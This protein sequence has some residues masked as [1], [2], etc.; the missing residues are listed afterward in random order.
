MS[1]RIYRRVSSVPVWLLLIVGIWTLPT[2]GLFVDSFRGRSDQIRGGFWTAATD[3]AQLT[4]DNY[5]IVLNRSGAYSMSDSLISSFAIVIPATIIP[6]FLAAL[7]AYGFAFIDFKARKWLFI[8]TISLI[9]VPIQVTL[10]PVLA[11]Y[12]HGAHLTI[13][14]SDR[15][16]TVF[17]DLDVNMRGTTAVWLTQ[18]GFALPFAIFLLHNAFTKLPQELI[19]SARIDG[20]DHVAIFRRLVLPLTIPAL[21]SLTILQFLWNWNDF[22]IPQIMTSGGDPRSL[23]TTVRLANLVGEPSSAGPVAA[24]GTFVQAAVPLLVFFA[25]QRHIVRGLLAG[26]VNG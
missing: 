6:I 19:D 8:G 10:I 20:A 5:D 21:M 14:F 15:T 25:L 9:V 17:P 18:T 7:A 24:A 26:A 3:P 4:L 23:P 11:T 13:P 12:V 16:I 1:G 22:L 2:V